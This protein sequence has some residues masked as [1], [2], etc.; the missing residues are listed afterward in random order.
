MVIKKMY[1]L[2]EK[3][4]PTALKKCNNYKLTRPM[5]RKDPKRERKTRSE[6]GM[7]SEVPSA[8]DENVVTMNVDDFT[9]NKRQFY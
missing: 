1:E 2:L 8:A 3:A 9:C 7:E 5:P 4:F 6:K